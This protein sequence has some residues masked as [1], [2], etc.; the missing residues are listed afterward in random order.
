[1]NGVQEN[2]KMVATPASWPCY[3]VLPMKRSSEKVGALPDLGYLMIR[4]GYYPE[5]GDEG[6]VVLINEPVPWN[7]YVDKE[8]LSYKVIPYESFDAML[9][10]GWMVD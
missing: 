7:M 9:S 10:D 5:S 4:E 3:P 6:P 2:K 8:R 1:M